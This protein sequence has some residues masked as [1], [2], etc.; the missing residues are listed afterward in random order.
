MIFGITD[1]LGNN[2]YYIY[3]KE[4]IVTRVAV[5]LSSEEPMAYITV[6]SFFFLWNVY[7]Y[8]DQLEFE[9]N[10]FIYILILQVRVEIS[11]CRL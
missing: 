11:F 9:M 1:Y 3:F 10:V 7:R 5:E 2:V 6:V 8:G 4:L